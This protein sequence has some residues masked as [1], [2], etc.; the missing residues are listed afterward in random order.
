MKNSKQVLILIV[1]CLFFGGVIGWSL[2]PGNVA[3]EEFAHSHSADT[4]YTCSMHPQIRQGE[5]GSCPICGMALTPV[6]THSQESDSPYQLKMTPSAVAL[7]NI[8]TTA[9]T[10][11]T[12]SPQFTLTGKIQPDET[13][14]A[15]IASN[16]SGR[17]D[18][19][20]A[21]FA[22]QVVKKGDRL[23]SIYAPE[24][25][26]AQKELLEAAKIKSDN[27]TLYQAA[28][29]KLTQ[30]RLTSSQIDKLESSAE[31]QHSFDVFAD[32]SGVVTAKNVAEGDFVTRGAVMFEMV[33]LQKVWVLLD[34]YENDLSHVKVGDKV[35]FTANAYPGQTFEG[36]VL[37]IDPA[38]DAQS[39]TVKVRVEAANPSSVLKPE[40]FV[41]AVLEAGSG[42]VGTSLVIPKSSVLWTGAKS[43]V[44]VQVGNQDEPAFEMREVALGASFGDQIAVNSGLQLG[45]KVVSSGAFAVDGAAQLSGNYSMM[46]RPKTLDVGAEVRSAFEKILGI[47]FE[48]KNHLVDSHAESAGLSASSLHKAIEHIDKEKL[49]DKDRQVWDE[50]SQS[51]MHHAHHIAQ[52]SDI[53]QQ[54][55]AFQPLSDQLIQLVEKVG[56]DQL[57][58]KQ[59]CPM[60]DQDKGAYWLSEEKA[61]RN[62]YFGESMLKCGEVKESFQKKS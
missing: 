24:L 41:S 61:V 54:R 10:S 34:V 52:V 16:F 2:K 26:S 21:T 40:M 57:V 14:R 11:G 6:Q 29:N 8:A 53:K 27:P 59:Y 31:V 47:Y 56:S 25:V 28:R 17:I 44:Y 62:P 12:Y 37:F 55:A 19:L 46:N 23:A 45:E 3:E 35:T 58:Y 18:K 38:L 15:S 5:P 1:G 50:L 42:D 48:L 39:R 51:L 22:G 20:Y 36:R 43:V 60:A 49:D 32:V 30:W 13:R 33:D 4:E 9:V 7:A